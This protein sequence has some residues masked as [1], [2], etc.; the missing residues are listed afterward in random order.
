MKKRLSG[1]DRRLLWEALSD[2][3]GEMVSVCERHYRSASS[4]DEATHKRLIELHA[5]TGEL[6][7]KLNP[8]RDIA[9]SNESTGAKATTMDDNI[10]DYYNRLVKAAPDMVDA[11]NE[12]V[13]DGGRRFTEIPKECVAFTMADAVLD[14]VN[15]T[16]PDGIAGAMLGHGDISVELA[17]EMMAALEEFV[18]A[19]GRF[20]ISPK[21]CVA[22]EMAEAALAKITK[23]EQKLQEKSHAKQS[24]KSSKAG[25]VID[26]KALSA[27]KHIA[28][29]K[30]IPA[31]MLLSHEAE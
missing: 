22:L 7:E 4:I 20:G 23:L 29:G 16:Y 28:K 12:F 9:P 13:L 27:L 24:K 6:L 2:N 21:D 26:P 1:A 30:A 19:Y 25:Q 31:D 17:Q 14:K 5:Y 10:P 15:A 18:A 3:A 11:L 8:S